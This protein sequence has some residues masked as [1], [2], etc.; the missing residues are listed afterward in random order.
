VF[1]NETVVSE[2]AHGFGS[3]AFMMDYNANIGGGDLYSVLSHL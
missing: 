2:L 3:N 1:R